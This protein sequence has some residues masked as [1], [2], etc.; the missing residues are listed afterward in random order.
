MHRRV[1]VVNA[2]YGSGQ[3]I[4]PHDDDFTFIARPQ[5]GGRWIA[6]DCRRTAF[7]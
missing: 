4:V 5:H 2:L 7:P 1:C 6:E 3:L